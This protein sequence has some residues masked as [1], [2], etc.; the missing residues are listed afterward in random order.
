MF[1]SLGSLLAVPLIA[2]CDES[3]PSVPAGADPHRADEDPPKLKADAEA[4]D[5]LL[6]NA[7]ILLE[8]AAINVY[9]AAAGLDF[10]RS[11][12]AV[13]KIAGQFMGHHTEHRDT[14]AGFVK[15]LGGEAA[16]PSTAQTPEIPALVLDE[17]ADPSDRKI[18]TL[19]FARKLERQA[20][21]TYHQLIVQ[22]LQT[23]MARRG[24]VEILPTE[25]QHVA[26]YDFVLQAEAPVNAALFSE[27]T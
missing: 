2:A 25:A 20:A 18:A 17:S 23:D 7:G 10:I 5:V 27:Q 9:T 8:Q 19:K 11:D 22:Q 15:K 4:N 24:A 1:L 21:E 16:D 26:I 3:T 12:A 6:L 13:I 14:L